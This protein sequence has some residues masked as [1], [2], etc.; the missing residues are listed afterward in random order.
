MPRGGIVRPRATWK[1]LLSSLESSQHIFSSISIAVVLPRPA[2]SLS[3]RTL[4]VLLL[5][6][7]LPP[8]RHLDHC[9]RAAERSA[10][11]PCSRRRRGAFA[12]RHRRCQ[13]PRAARPPPLGPLSCVVGGIA[14][15]GG[16]DVVVEADTARDEGC[17]WRVPRPRFSPARCF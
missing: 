6:L 1:M 12:S 4:K 17:L 7:V 15:V 2:P 3:S 13:A 16:V 14:V 11:S 9:A 10:A 8:Q 5:R